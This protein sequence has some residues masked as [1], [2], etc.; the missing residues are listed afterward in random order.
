MFVRMTPSDG[1]GQS[2]SIALR[3]GEPSRNPVREELRDFG[4]CCD[5]FWVGAQDSS[6]DR[7][8][9]IAAHKSSHFFWGQ[10]DR[11]GT[12][13]AFRGQV[14]ARLSE[15]ARPARIFVERVDGPGSVLVGDRVR[16]KERAGRYVAV[17]L[18]RLWLRGKPPSPAVVDWW[19]AL[20]ARRR[21]DWIR[22]PLSGDAACEWRHH[23]THG[24]GL[25][26]LANR[27]ARRWAQRPRCT[28]RIALAEPALDGVQDRERFSRDNRAG[29]AGQADLR[30]GVRG[31]GRV[32]GRPC[33]AA[34]GR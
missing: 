23:S 17:G 26:Q 7:W 30:G 14:V 22:R 20:Q 5:W 24:S 19:T 34:H 33:H 27:R 18:E 6:D 29:D 11:Y 25:G 4:I 8:I 28:A 2:Q 13:E 3:P 21:P 16:L 9:A 10:C 31:F 1:V 12:P 32:R 15:G